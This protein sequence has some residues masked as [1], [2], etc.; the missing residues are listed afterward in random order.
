MVARAIHQTSTRHRGRFVAI[1]VSAIPETLLD[2]EL[3]GHVRGAFTGAVAMR[4]GRLEQADGGTLF[5]DEVGTMPMALQM[6]MLRV[7]QERE[8]E[9]IGD[10]KTIKVDVRIVAA[11]NRDL[12]ALVTA[13]HFRQDLYFR[14][15]AAIVNLP[16][17]RERLSDLPYL[18]SRLLVDLGRE[19][20]SVAPETLAVLRAHPWPGNV[21]ELKNVLAYA[22]A[23]V[24]AGVLLPRHLRFADPPA[25]QTMLDRLPLGG[26]ALQALERAAIK[27]T[28]A[29]VSG[30]R[31]HAARTLGIAPS[32]L[33]EKLRKY[34]L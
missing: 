17:L 3:F 20:V 4:Q 23:F 15:A 13:R 29:Q 1:N 16:P 21:R 27:Q 30:N 9:R 32:T 26:H 22:I 28:L 7:L 19:D 18:V 8:F 12:G 10:T 2:A 11:T 33:Y 6:K 34:G 14:L 25:E 5:L 31:V 24:D